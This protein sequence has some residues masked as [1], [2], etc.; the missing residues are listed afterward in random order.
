MLRLSFVLLAVCAPIILCTAI[1]CTAVSST[2]AAEPEF[3][4]LFDGKSLEGWT[5]RGGAATYHVEDGC[6]VGVV[7]DRRNNTF[8]CSN[9]TF[10]NFVFLAEFKFDKPFN[11]GIQFRSSARP[12]GDIE[13]VFGYQYEIDTTKSTGGVYDEGRRAKFLAPDTPEKLQAGMTAFKQGD[14]NTVKIQCIGPCIQTWINDFL[15]TDFIDLETQRGYF[16]LQVHSAAD[17]QIRWK[18]IRVQ[19][20]PNTPWTNLF[21]PADGEDKDEMFKHLE[22]KPAGSWVKQEDGSYHATSEAAE[23]RDGMVLS[24]DKYPNAAVRIQ[25]KQGKGNSGL[26]FRATEIDTP[27]WIQGIQG[28]ID[29]AAT[30]GLWEVKGRGWIF[31]PPKDKIATIFKTD[32][33]NELVVVAQDDHIRT[34]LNGVEIA[35]LKDDTIARDGKVGLQLHGGSD[36]DYHFRKFEVMPL[37]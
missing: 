34:V 35:N 26:Y 10:E 12:Q 28:E 13:R 31:P 36:M 14:W 7:A 17:G 21:T 1:L 18:N 24:K 33:W 15:V 9:E 6:I 16:G 37:P 22:V 2:P 23:K 19:E 20:L 3:R 5:K 25:F 29:T 32:D 8:L 30:G 27:Y 11:S 4:S